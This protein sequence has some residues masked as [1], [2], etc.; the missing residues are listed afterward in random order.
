M[1]SLYPIFRSDLTVERVKGKSCAEQKCGGAVVQGAGR[2][3]DKGGKSSKAQGL[4]Q[5]GQGGQPG[6]GQAQQSFEGRDKKNEFN[7]TA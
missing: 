3:R 6:R 1:S 4:Q 5:V 7:I 2:R